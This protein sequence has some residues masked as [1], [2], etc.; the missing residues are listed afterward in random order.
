MSV[1]IGTV[2]LR[3]GFF[4]A[5]CLACLTHFSSLRLFALSFLFICLHEL[6]H[7]LMMRFFGCRR[8]FIEVL[9]GGVRMTAEDLPAVGYRRTA[10]VLLSAPAANLLSGA[11]LLWLARRFSAPFL[12]QAAL[13]DMTLGA[14]N[15]LPLSILDGGRALQ[16]VIASHSRL[17]DA[18]KA[19]WIADA[20]CLS[21]IGFALALLAYR[22]V[23]PVPLFC[24]FLY[25]VFSLSVRRKKTV[26]FSRKKAY[27]SGVIT[28]KEPLE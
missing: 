15:L 20:V 3:I 25:C 26:D 4:T 7:L 9:P 14:V 13:V 5:V 27:D 19:A 21:A 10:V 6:T 17:P 24:F 28:S 8:T 18:G 16:C 1:E 11:L 12:R 23:F 22:R 2:R